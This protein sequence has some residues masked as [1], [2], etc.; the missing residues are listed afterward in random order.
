MDEEGLFRI[1]LVDNGVKTRP[2]SDRCQTQYLQLAGIIWILANMTY[3][4]T[5]KD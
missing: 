3:I 2:D 5:R 4:E 1:Y